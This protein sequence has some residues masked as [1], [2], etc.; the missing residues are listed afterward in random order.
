MVEEV[1]IDVHLYGMLKD[2]QNSLEDLSFSSFFRLMEVPR[3]VNELV[4]KTRK[5]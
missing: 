4:R 2:Y 1:F 5:V 3:R